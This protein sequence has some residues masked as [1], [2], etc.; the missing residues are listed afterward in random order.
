MSEAEQV[1]IFDAIYAEEKRN[2]PNRK[3][4]KSEAVAQVALP[5]TL[6]RYINHVTGENRNGSSKQRSSK[7]KKGE[8]TS[9]AE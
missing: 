5:R 3:G 7:Y 6:V 4:L 9:A 8:T 2:V 1:A